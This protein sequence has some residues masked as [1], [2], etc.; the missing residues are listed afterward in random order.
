MND[1]RWFRLVAGVFAV[2]LL[3]AA[4]GGDDE[5][6][7]DGGGST[8]DGGGPTGAGD[9]ATLTIEGFAFDPAT[10]QVAAGDATITV[11]NNDQATHSFTTDD[12][13]VDEEIPAGETV[14]VTLSVEGVDSLGF[15][16][17][18][19]PNMTGTLEIG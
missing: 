5:G 16:C 17:R 10:L 12:D 6:G 18:F 8:G 7:G 4:C 1:R 13:A 15:H 14:D 9:G 19:H 2:S 3:V 11:T